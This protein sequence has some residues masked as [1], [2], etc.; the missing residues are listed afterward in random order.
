MTHI[1][2][3]VDKP[4]SSECTTIIVEKAKRRDREGC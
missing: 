4:G 2:R 3:D 1:M